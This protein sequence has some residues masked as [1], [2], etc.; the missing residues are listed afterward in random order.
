MS[1]TR[2]RYLVAGLALLG[3]FAFPPVGSAQGP[4]DTLRPRVVTTEEAKPVSGLLPASDA[5][6]ATLT[7]S[8]VSQPARGV[9]VLDDAVTGAFTVHAEP[10]HVRVRPVHLRGA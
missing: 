3:T 8:I 9:V 4:A 6:S 1:S 5:G 10:W 7:F 2:T